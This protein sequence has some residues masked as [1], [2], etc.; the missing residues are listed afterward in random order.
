MNETTSERL[1]VCFACGDEIE[2]CEFCDGEECP[3]AMCYGCVI[4]AIG[5]EIPQLRRLSW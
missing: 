3:K 1:N 4:V 5:Q 2:R